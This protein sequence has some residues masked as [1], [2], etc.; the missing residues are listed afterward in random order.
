VSIGRLVAIARRH[1]RRMPMQE[2]AEGFVSVEAGLAG[3]CKG[4]KF[5]LRQVTVLAREAWEAA[6]AEAGDAGLPWTVPRQSAGRGRRVAQEQGGVLRIGPVRLEVT[7][8]TYP[9]LRM[10][11]AR[12]GLLR[13]LARDWPRP[14]RR[15]HMPWRGRGGAGARA[16]GPP[17]VALIARWPAKRP[18]QAHEAQKK[19]E[20]RGQGPLSE[21]TN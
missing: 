20:T 5:P 17:A 8:Q 21:S 13:A 19:P 18:F 9:C 3:D 2:I 4:A 7:G 1:Q 11:E 12:A 15:Q 16:R 6:A 10:E 14:G